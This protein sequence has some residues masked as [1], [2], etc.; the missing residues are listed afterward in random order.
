MAD[1]AGDDTPPAALPAG[2]NGGGTPGHPDVPMLDY[3]PPPFGPRSPWPRF[4]G[5]VLLGGA[6]AYGSFVVGVIAIIG[7]FNGLHGSPPMWTNILPF[8]GAVVVM[9]GGGWVAWT[10]ERRRPFG[11]GLVVSVPLAAMIT[12]SVCS[13][14]RF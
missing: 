4:V 10:S 2:V 12:L 3:Q 7:P 5:G 9:A 8:I 6:L 13:V 14:G 1:D 11:L